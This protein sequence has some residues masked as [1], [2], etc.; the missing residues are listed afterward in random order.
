MMDNFD[1]TRIVD[2]VVSKLGESMYQLPQQVKEAVL[3]NYILPP[4][5]IPTKNP[6][7]QLCLEIYITNT[8]GMI[9]RI[10]D[11]FG[12]QLYERSFT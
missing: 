12:T 5:T 10:R 11:T 6:A 1:I 8:G 3:K 2:G 9:W 7:D 4:M